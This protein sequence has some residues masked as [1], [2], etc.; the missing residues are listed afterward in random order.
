MIKSRIKLA[1]ILCCY[2]IATSFKT[3]KLPEVKIIHKSICPEGGKESLLHPSFIVKLV[4]YDGDGKSE[5][6]K[7]LVEENKFEVYRHALSANLVDTSVKYASNFYTPSILGDFVFTDINGDA[8]PDL[9]CS[10]YNKPETKVYFTR[11][12]G[13]FIDTGISLEECIY[14]EIQP[15]DIDSDGD[16]D[17]LLTGGN[18]MGFID[19]KSKTILYL[20]EG[21]ILVNSEAINVSFS[22]GIGSVAVTQTYD[23]TMRDILVNN[24]SELLLYQYDGKGN[25]NLKS[26]TEFDP[27]SASIYFKVQ[28]TE[29]NGDSLDDV[30]AITNKGIKVFL[31]KGHGNYSYHSQSVKLT[32]INRDKHS[33]IIY[34]DDKNILN[35]YVSYGAG[36]YSLNSFTIPIKINCYTTLQCGYFNMDKEPDFLIQGFSAKGELSTMKFLNNGDGTFNRKKNLKISVKKV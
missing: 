27:A 36:I 25:I 28:F 33:D 30:L 3:T 34:I 11:K 1:T 8:I 32:D 12:D 14:G 16:T 13:R 26:R 19:Q 7:Y 31:N 5:F 6:V 10:A 20:N 15:L 21:G 29:I 23:G 9:I 18:N 2:F 22:G 24:F 17:I 35:L 4:D